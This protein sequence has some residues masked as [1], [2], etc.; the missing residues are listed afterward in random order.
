[1]Q[2][3]F[4]VPNLPKRFVNAI[5]AEMNMYTMYNQPLF[6]P[7]YGHEMSA[8][9]P[10]WLIIAWAESGIL[11][12]IPNLGIKTINDVIEL[13]CEELKMKI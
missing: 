2:F 10:A 11:K 7:S 8:P 6:L 13:I 4:T 12:R 9:I 3:T 1:M 5:N